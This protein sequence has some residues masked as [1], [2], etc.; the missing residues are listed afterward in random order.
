MYNRIFGEVKDPGI[1]IIAEVPL[2]PELAR[3][4]DSSELISYLR[5]ENEVSR[6]F[7]GLA[8]RVE[9]FMDAQR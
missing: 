9:Q 3:A 7:I 6:A 4:I 8:R 2:D 1:E 5:K